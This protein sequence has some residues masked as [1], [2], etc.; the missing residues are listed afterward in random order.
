M[1]EEA[2]PH[3]L[4]SVYLSPNGLGQQ[5]YELGKAFDENDPYFRLGRFFT[6]LNSLTR[7]DWKSVTVFF[8]TDD[9]WAELR[10]DI[11]LKIA[12][13]FPA[14]EITPSRLSLAHDWR[15]VSEEYA[16]NEII[17]LHC[18]DD[19][20]FVSET[21]DDF[22]NLVNLMSADERF[23][24]GG[25]THHPEMT[26]LKARELRVGRVRSSQNSIKV[27]YALGTTLV[28]G[29]F[30]KT[31][32]IPGKFSSDELVVRPDNPLGKSVTF[33]PEVM[34]LPPM[35]Q[36][37]HLDGYSHIGLFRPLAPLRNTI[38]YF[39]KD[40]PLQDLGAWTYGYWPAP[41]KSANGY[42]VDLHKVDIAPNM[43]Y[44]QNI[45]VGV[46]RIQS[47]C[48][49]RISISLSLLVLKS[50]TRVSKWAT[51]PTL[52]IGISTKSVARN[53]ISYLLDMPMIFILSLLKKYTNLE[54]GVLNRIWYLGLTR[55]IHLPAKPSLKSQ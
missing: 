23:K 45:Q 2:K 54:L 50:R 48:A 34:L 6:G 44:V 18:N 43:S 1:T 38:T 29:D 14:A 9:A 16:D 33:N 39:G 32:W 20:A 15:S 55:A 37:R 42:G 5:R 17:Y 28:R 21:T 7:I 12:N 25:I 41:I 36:I 24:L 13:I 3:L 22:Y 10:K 47:T 46:A 52:L 40:L 53:L 49:L 35:E 27:G 4:I 31:W 30:F 51:V 8:D 26:G 11:G 19:H